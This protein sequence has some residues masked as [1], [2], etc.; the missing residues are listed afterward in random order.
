MIE[1]MLSGEQWFVLWT[2]SYDIWY[3]DTSVTDRKLRRY[4]IWNSMYK[5][6]F[7]LEYIESIDSTGNSCAYVKGTEQ[8]INWF[9][10]QL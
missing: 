10:L 9:I 3:T 6:K 1:F 2:P 5:P 7:H 4:A 8:N